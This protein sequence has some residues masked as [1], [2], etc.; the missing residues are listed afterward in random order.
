VSITALGR[1]ARDREEEPVPNGGDEWRMAWHPPDAVPPGTPHGANA[2][3]VTAD[4][5]VVLISSDGSRWGWPGG[6]PERGESWEDTLRREMLEE[7]CAE[8]TSARLLGFVR[9]RCV[10]G[11]E[12][13]LV[14]VR[15]IW[16]ADVSLRPW[17]PEF[18]IPFRRVVPAR[19]LALNLWMED[20]AGPIYS[21]AAREAAL[22]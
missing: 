12:E 19:D 16:R 1:M 3:C 6:R 7:A 17:Q 18:E 15:S 22:A 4:G 8:V 5:D 13:G 20:G 21:R 14:L 9:S 10:S 2:F 11:A